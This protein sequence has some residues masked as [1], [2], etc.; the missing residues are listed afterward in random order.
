MNFF[1]DHDVY[2]QTIRFLRANGHAVTRAQD[3]GLASAEDSIVLQYAASSNLILITRDKGFGALVFKQQVTSR[4][5]IFLRIHPLTISAVH[6]QLLR[7]LVELTEAEIRQSF[8]VVEATQY[9]VRKI[10]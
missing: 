3:V 8:I 10:S 9:R 7:V 5:V 2:G 6:K 1:T 4:G